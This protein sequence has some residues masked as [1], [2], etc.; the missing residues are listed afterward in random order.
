M[1]DIFPNAS[2]NPKQEGSVKFLRKVKVTTPPYSCRECFVIYETAVI[3]RGIYW[4]PVFCAR[5]VVPKLF[6]CIPPWLRKT[7]DLVT[8]SF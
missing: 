5:P 1:A 8:Y 4:F 2:C 6:R 3:C 7:F